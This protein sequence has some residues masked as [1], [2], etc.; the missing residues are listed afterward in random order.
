LLLEEYRD[1]IEKRIN[2]KIHIN[3][4]YDPKKRLQKAVPFKPAIYVDF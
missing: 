2:G 4:D 1:Y 3:S